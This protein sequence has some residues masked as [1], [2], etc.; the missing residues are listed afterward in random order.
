MCWYV[1]ACK[2]LFPPSLQ[3]LSTESMKM[4]TQKIGTH[5]NFKLRVHFSII[6]ISR[7]IDNTFLFPLHWQASVAQWLVALF[8]KW[9]HKLY[10]IHCTD[11]KLCVVCSYGNAYH[12]YGIVER[13]NIKFSFSGEAI[14]VY[15]EK[16]NYSLMIIILTLWL[17]KINICGVCILFCVLL[18]WY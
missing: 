16:T 3:P 5:L 6:P 13:K 9:K 17:G 4:K 7:C 8:S 11:H 12:M 10:S 1:I 2:G 15:G 14:W 18:Y